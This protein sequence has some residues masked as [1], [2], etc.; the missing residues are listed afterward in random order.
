MIAK[1]YV[2]QNIRP[3]KIC[4]INEKT[5]KNYVTGKK[6]KKKGKNCTKMDETKFI[7]TKKFF[8]EISNSKKKMRTSSI[9]SLG[10]EEKIND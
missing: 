9:Y 1:F 2:E 5:L 3:L 6:E 8:E 7:Y 10:K 4:E